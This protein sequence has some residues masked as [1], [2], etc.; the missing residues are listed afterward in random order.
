MPDLPFCRRGK[1]L[2][3]IL[4]LGFYSVPAHAG[5]GN[6]TSKKGK[7]GLQ[8]AL[9]A[10]G[11]CVPRVVIIKLKESRNA[12]ATQAATGLTALD[13]RL[14]KH[15]IFR[16]EP[17]LSQ[18]QVLHAAQARV[19]LSRI[20]FAH[21]NSAV[22]PFVVAEDLRQDSH[23][24]YAEPKFIHTLAASPNDPD[25]IDQSFYATIKAAQ[26]W[27][28]VKGE[29]GNTVVAVVD[30]GSDRDHPDLQANFWVNGDEIP[31]NGLDDDNNGYTDDVNGW[32]FA[33]NSGDP[34][35][36]N[37]T[38]NNANHGT[39]TA[40][41]ACAVSNNRVGV[42]GMSWNARLMGLNAGSA[43]SDRSINFGYEGVLYAANNGAH[44]ISLS[45][46][47]SGGG[48]AFEQEVIDYATGLG[49][50]VVAAA[51]NDNSPASYYPAAYRNVLAVA[52]TAN[53]DVR[54]GS[55]NFGPWVDVSAPG[56]NILSTVNNG[57]YDR[58]TGTSMSSPLVAGLVALVKTQHPNWTGIQASE[59][60][61]VTADNVEAL[62]PGFAGALGR[63]R[64]NAQ[65]ALTESAPSL[66]LAGVTITDAD[67][68]GVIEPNESV[69]VQ[70]RIINYLA[71]AAN[72]SLTLSENDPNVTLNTSAGTI[73]AIGTLEEKTPAAPFRFTVAANAP[74]G[75]PIDFTLR[76]AAGNYNDADRFTLTILPTYGSL[77]VNNIETT[78][79][80]IGRLG[81]GDPNQSGL[82][83]GFKYQGGQSL[84]FEGAIICGNSV[85]RISN[86]ARGVLLGTNLQFDQDFTV[87]GGGDLRVLRPGTRTD[88]ESTGIF[89]D[90]AAGS[91]MNIRLTQETF[92]AARAPYDDVILL[93]YTVENLNAAE[94]NNFYFGYFFDWDIGPSGGG[95]IA[96]YDATR[97]LGYC[98]NTT[99]GPRT[100][101]GMALIEGSNTSFRA[102]FNNQNAPG[103]PSWGVYD[104]FSDAEKWESLLGGVSIK[105]AG[106][107]DVSFVIGSG[108]HRISARGKITLGFALLAGTNL[109]DLQANA[110]AAAQFW[111]EL[112]NTA[113]E[114]GPSPSLP[115]IFALEQNYPNPFNP[116]TL[117]RFQL[118]QTS[119]LQLEI[120][121]ATGRKIRTLWQ[122]K[123]SGGVYAEKWDGRNDSGAPAPSGVYVYRLQTENFVHSRKMILLR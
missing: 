76:L 102:I 67:G 61:R 3:L 110:E 56:T 121:D 69:S 108:P 83:V 58:Y 35:G 10:E 104:G 19:D 51:G 71:P 34:S 68:D 94:L 12:S 111:S 13:T 120:F 107:D 79:T 87:A 40:G 64:I 73:A 81:Y 70:T 21:F 11:E 30:G 113:V 59:Q 17:L 33:N 123:R 4:A 80:N 55:S 6:Q 99:N 119:V 42:A 98:Y 18:A 48:S 88:Q 97:R 74:S 37:S 22:S 109:Q 9:L 38:P 112:F 106:P 91:P 23:L 62:N 95:D 39:H 52:N 44:V 122:G 53:N 84:L 103:N 72:V 82:G 36:L 29:Q 25:F 26:A 116:E 24:E 118:P 66:R 115:R 28:V 54:N 75:H 46:G 50:A 5:A 78:V 41:L 45:W 8:R 105:K 93:R 16:L 65:R 89:E 63:G 2:A 43:T 7:A 49:V 96:D 60:V 101:A 15:G 100:H 85:S 47:R 90:K 14:Q 1:I 86:A 92:A 27:D 32:N 31:G 20:Y 114:E 77:S 57:L 117:V